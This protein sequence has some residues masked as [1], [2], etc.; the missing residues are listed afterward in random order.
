MDLHAANRAAADAA[1]QINVKVK[2]KLL[3][4]A[5]KH[6]MTEAE[7]LDLAEAW[8]RAASHTRRLPLGDL[9]NGY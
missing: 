4:R 8:K 5:L 1:A 7:A 2:T 6:G 9:R 3:K